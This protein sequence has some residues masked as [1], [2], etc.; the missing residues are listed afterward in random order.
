MPCSICNHPQRPAIDQALLGGRATLAA[1]ARQYGLSTSALH[2]HYDHLQEKQR[3]AQSRNRA[4]LHLDCLTKLDR[5][6]DLTLQT[7]ETASAEGNH[8]VVIQAAREAT[9]IVSLINKMTQSPSSKSRNL[10]DLKGDAASDALGALVGELLQVA[11][12]LPPEP[13]P[14]PVKP[15][16]TTCSRWEK[17]GKRERKGACLEKNRKEYQEDIV[18]KKSGGKNAPAGSLLRQLDAGQLD[19]DYLTAIGAGRKIPEP[20]DV[21]PSVLAAAPEARLTVF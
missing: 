10:P 13:P 15:F 7:A 1:L 20:L 8:K 16:E 2:R 3:R 21:F 6:L 14:A 18:Q 17:S 19:F 11:A 4:Q 12:N 9:R 5:I